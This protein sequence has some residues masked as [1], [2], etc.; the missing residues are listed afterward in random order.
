ML[1]IISLVRS[2]H[3]IDFSRA[4]EVKRHLANKTVSP[5]PLVNV[6]PTEKIADQP[7]S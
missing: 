1:A 5:P 6:P 7:L 2:L 3:P 4:F